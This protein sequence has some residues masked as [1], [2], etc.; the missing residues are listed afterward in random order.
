[1]QN[2]ILGRGFS[3]K[4]FVLILTTRV[5]FHYF[6]LKELLVEISFGYRPVTGSI[7]TFFWILH[8]TVFFDHQNNSQGCGDHPR[9]RWIASC[10]GNGTKNQCAQIVGRI[11]L[12]YDTQKP[13]IKR[14]QIPYKCSRNRCKRPFIQIQRF[15]QPY[16]KYP[17]KTMAR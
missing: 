12:P 13:S 5:I 6:P 9:Q 16:Q 15:L 2:P 4:G 1:M 3:Q 11:P 14:Y 10:I 8:E 17:N 7:S